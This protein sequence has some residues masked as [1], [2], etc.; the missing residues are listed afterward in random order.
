MVIG[1]PLSW[2]VGC[3]TEKAG[4]KITVQSDSNDLQKKAKEDKKMKKLG[5]ALA[6]VIAIGVFASIIW[7]ACP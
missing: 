7:L 4:G 1:T 6:L 2:H 3:S 5:I